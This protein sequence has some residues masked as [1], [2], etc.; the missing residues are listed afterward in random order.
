M[1]NSNGSKT[2]QISE[3]LAKKL[4]I[5]AIEQDKTRREMADEAIE[6]YLKNK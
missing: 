4:A 1:A 6:F 5:L 3:E 2:I